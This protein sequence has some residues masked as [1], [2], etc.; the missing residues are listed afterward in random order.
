MNMRILTLAFLTGLWH[1]NQGTAQELMPLKQLELGQTTQQF[2]SL[3]PDAKMVFDK[4]QAGILVEGLAFVKIPTNSFWSNS[5]IRFAEGRVATIAYIQTED[6]GRAFTN[7]PIIL[8]HL[9]KLEGTNYT[10]AVAIQLGKTG[11]VDSPVLIWE[12]ADRMLAYTFMP[13]E[14]YKPGEPFVCQ[15]TV[16]PKGKKLGDHL[17]LVARPDVDQKKVFKSVDEAISRPESP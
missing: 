7:T 5:G 12:K 11:K 8:R 9:I 4:R 2:S 1:I 16:F 14:T 15:L 17:E 6:F 3:F 10:R 13:L